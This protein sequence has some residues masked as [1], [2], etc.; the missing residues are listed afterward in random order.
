MKSEGTRMPASPAASQLFCGGCAPHG[1]MATRAL[2][3]GRRCAWNRGSPASHRTKNP[4]G[5]PRARELPREPQVE[6][7]PGDAASRR[8][9]AAVARAGRGER[10]V[11]A[12]GVAD[13]RD[14]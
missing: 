5:V 11:T 4:P 14:A 1:A 7:P 9:L 3:A 6:V 13:D 8:A 10:A 2:T 12:H